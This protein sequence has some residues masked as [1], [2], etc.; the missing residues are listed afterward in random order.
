M[1]DDPF[2]TTGISGGAPGTEEEVELGEDVEGDFSEEVEAATSWDPLEYATTNGEQRPSGAP[3]CVDVVIQRSGNRVIAYSGVASRLLVSAKG[4]YAGSY[5]RALQWKICVTM[6]IA[7]HLIEKGLGSAEY[8]DDS[9]EPPPAL[10]TNEQLREVVRPFF[11]ERTG[12]SLNTYIGRLK[13]TCTFLLPDGRLVRLGSFVSA[14]RPDVRITQELVWQVLK[15]E[16]P[17]SPYTDSQIA[18]LVVPDAA[19]LE[20]ARASVARIR[21]EYLR[22]PGYQQRKRL[23]EQGVALEDMTV[24]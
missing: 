24:I 22:K 16:P 13:R 9:R 12:N 11:R 3:A 18:R 23:Y 17:E 2:E 6:A 7:M 5:R 14:D 10:T 8:Q 15:S 1:S 4:P 19:R 21:K 20:S